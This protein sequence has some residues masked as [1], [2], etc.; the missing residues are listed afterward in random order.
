M[1]NTNQV[2]TKHPD[3]ESWLKWLLLLAFI[4]GVALCLFIE[5]RAIK[6]SHEPDLLLFSDTLKSLL[7]M[8]LFS[9]LYAFA[10]L[11]LAKSVFPDSVKSAKSS[12]SGLGTQIA[13]LSVE[14]HQAKKGTLSDQLFLH[15]MAF[16]LLG[17]LCFAILRCIGLSPLQLI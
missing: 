13:E 1:K 14:I 12:G 6:A 10:W 9:V 2:T 5:L 3:R 15:G 17:V 11:W 4:N 8:G 16:S 7:P